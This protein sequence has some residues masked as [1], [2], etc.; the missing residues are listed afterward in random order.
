MIAHLRFKCGIRFSFL[1]IYIFAGNHKRIKFDRRFFSHLCLHE[2][3]HI[4]DFFLYFSRNIFFY[5]RHRYILQLFKRKV[6]N[7]LIAIFS[8]LDYNAWGIWNSFLFSYL[9]HFIFKRVAK[10]KQRIKF[11]ARILNYQCNG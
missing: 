6:S 10:S 1:L 4:S 3:D 11:T 5:F 2:F 7:C 9:Y 8:L